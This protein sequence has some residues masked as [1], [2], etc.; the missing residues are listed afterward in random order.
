[1]CLN[2]NQT[3][4]AAWCKYWVKHPWIY[5]LQKHTYLSYLHVVSHLRVGSTSKV[6][7]K[8]HPRVK[9]PLMVQKS[10]SQPPGMVLWNLVN[11]RISTTFPS[12]GDVYR[13]SGWHQ[14]SSTHTYGCFLKWWVPPNH[15]NFHRV[16]HSKPS[17]LGY[18]HFRKHPYVTSLSGKGPSRVTSLVWLWDRGHPVLFCFGFWWASLN[19]NLVGREWRWLYLWP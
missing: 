10:Q 12:T 8:A 18:H 4:G 16:F 15:P 11:N 9:T 7:K 6:F 2:S 1:M 14:Q 3:Q 19:K 13:I 5:L 17:I